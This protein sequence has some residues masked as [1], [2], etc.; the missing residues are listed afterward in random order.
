M[1]DCDCRIAVCRMRI[2]IQS[3]EAVDVLA[4]MLWGGRVDAVLPDTSDID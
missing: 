3:P 2:F 4:S 1:V